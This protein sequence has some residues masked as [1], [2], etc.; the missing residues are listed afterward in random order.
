[1]GAKVFRIERKCRGPH[2]LVSMIR[3]AAAL[4]LSAVAQASSLPLSVEGFTAACG[5]EPANVYSLSSASGRATFSG[6]HVSLDAKAVELTFSYLGAGSSFSWRAE[7]PLDARINIIQGDRR[8]WCLDRPVFQRLEG[9]SI[10]PG[11]SVRFALTDS[12][13]KSQYDLSPGADPGAIRMRFQGAALSVDAGGSLIARAKNAAWSERRPV[14]WQTVDGVQ[15]PVSCAWTVDGDVASFSLGPYNPELPLTIDPAVSYSTYLGNA[16]NS[17]FSAATSTAADSQGNVWV[18]GWMEGS[19]LGIGGA[20]TGS[21]DAFL[22]KLNSAGAV[23]FAT[24]FGGSGDDRALGVAVDSLGQP[25]ITGVTS[26][27]NLPVLNP[28]QRSLGGY[29]NAFIAQFSGSGILK[30]STYYGGAGPDSGNGVAVDSQGSAYVTGDTQSSNFPVKLPL[31]ASLAGGQDAFVVKINSSGALVYATYLGGSANDHGAAAAVD[32]SGAA[33]ITGQTQSANFPAKGPFQAALKGGA[34]A[35]AAKLSADGS[36]LVYA[37]FLGGSAGSPLS[38]EQGNSIAVDASGTAYIAGV[39]PSTDF[40]VTSGAIRNTQS[41]QGGA[42]LAKIDPSG[43]TIAY[44]TY[45]GGSGSD[46][47]TSVVVDSFG[48]VCVAGYTTSPDFPTNGPAQASAGGS[49]DGF[50]SILNPAGTG[51]YFSSLWGGSGSDVINGAALDYGGNLYLAGQTSSLDFPLSNQ[52]A[53]SHAAGI[54]SFLVKLATD[55]ATS[56]IYRLYYGVYGASPTA[57]NLAQWVPLLDQG[58][59]TRSQ[60]ALSFFNDAGYQSIGFN[61][62]GAYLAVFARNF[63][64]GGFQF[65]MSLYRSGFLASQTCSP[66][67]AANSTDCA[68]NGLIGDFLAAPEFQNTYGSLSNSDFIKKVG[69]GNVLGRNPD[70]GGLAYWTSIL[71]QG[72][73]TRAWVLLN[74]F[75]NGPEFLQR[76]GS[77]IQI[78]LAYAGFL[79]RSPTA[80]ELQNGIIALNNGVNISSIISG[81]VNG[82]E[83]KYAF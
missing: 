81:L 16:S 67:T 65:W 82:P 61:V 68:K 31:Q 14:A 45:L 83:F 13:L 38:P 6:P 30:F 33:Y 7:R 51:Y 77:Q 43:A 47:A 10:Y 59:Q 56:F 63:D 1:M 22:I 48:S 15:T 28:I 4:I 55:D 58:A 9:Q 72:L 40:P 41:G 3:F 37:S 26:S 62:A 18:A 42:F 53:R 49:Y 25:W 20:S 74:G 79:L 23:Q 35:F 73:A 21:V 76:F 12:R 75:I 71:D 46:V 60:V 52:L 57:A 11:V 69:Y 19:N 27:S 78:E 29:R 8:G 70:S 34:D 54:D 32:S 2:S 66:V 64:I 36:A 50:V 44:A 39:T 5:P 17:G 24:Y 80:T